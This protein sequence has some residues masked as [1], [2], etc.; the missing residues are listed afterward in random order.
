MG[1]WKD[2]GSN[3]P[4]WDANDAG[5]DQ[6]KPPAQE[7]GSDAG[8]S[9]DAAGVQHGWGPIKI[10][11]TYQPHPQSPGDFWSHIGQ[12][13]PSQDGNFS[14]GPSTSMPWEQKPHVMPWEGTGQM[15]NPDVPIPIMPK[16]DMG[17]GG[18]DPNIMIPPMSHEGGSGMGG[19]GMPPSSPDM[20]QSLR[21]ILGGS[22]GLAS[23]V[24]NPQAQNQGQGGMSPLVQ[25]LLARK[26]GQV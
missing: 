13:K 12:M 15:A 21:G 18:M 17:M 26:Q 20:M 24:G 7:G 2:N 9:T 14:G 19:F 23:M 22:S 8:T 4:I 25:Q 11:G 5:P 16:G 1:R 3:G 10:S 6:I